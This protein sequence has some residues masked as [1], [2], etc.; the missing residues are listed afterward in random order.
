MRRVITVTVA[1]LIVLL[2]VAYSAPTGHARSAQGDNYQCDW[3][4]RTFS[5][6]EGWNLGTYHITW[7]NWDGTLAHNDNRFDSSNNETYHLYTTGHDQTTTSDGT[8]QYRWTQIIRGGYSS[9]YEYVDEW[10]HNGC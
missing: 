8:D 1:A 3:Y 2:A 9:D 6:N 4:A 7:S 5:N 10:S